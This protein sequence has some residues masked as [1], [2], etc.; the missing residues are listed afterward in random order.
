MG[1]TVKAPRNPIGR[2]TIRIP[3]SAMG[4]FFSFFFV[5]AFRGGSVP[6][7][8]TGFFG[9]FFVGPLAVRAKEDERGYRAG[10]RRYREK[11]F[12]SRS[13]GAADQMLHSLN[14][15]RPQHKSTCIMCIGYPHLYPQH[16][17]HR[18]RRQRRRGS[19]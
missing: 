13:R 12:T 15:S 7:S 1:A 11:R 2:G 8:A 9:V 18:F 19:V 4:L 3:P 17:R 16:G 10:K 5:R 14:G 6:R